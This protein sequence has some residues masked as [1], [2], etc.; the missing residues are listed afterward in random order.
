LELI[1]PDR[2]SLLGKGGRL[3]ELGIA[4]PRGNGFGIDLVLKSTRPGISTERGPVETF[5]RSGSKTVWA[6]DSTVGEKLIS[7]STDVPAISGGR[8]TGSDWAFDDGSGTP[9][10]PTTTLP[11]IGTVPAAY[12]AWQVSTAYSIGD[13]IISTDTLKSGLPGNGYY[14]VATSGGT[15][16]ASEPTWPTTIGGT[17]ADNGVTWECKGYYTHAA[18]H[19]EMGITNKNTN[20]NANPDAL[21]TGVSVT[22]ATAITR[23]AD[24]T[25]L[26]AA[27]LSSVCSDGNVFEYINDTGAS[28]TITIGGTVGNLNA[29]SFGVFAQ[30]S[31]GTVTMQ[32]TGGATTDIT[33][34]DYSLT[35]AENVTPLAITDQLEFTVPDGVTFRWVLNQLEEHPFLTSPIITTGAAASHSADSLTHPNVVHNP[36]GMAWTMG[37]ASGE[38]SSSIY[39]IYNDY[40]PLYARFTT[41]QIFM[42]DGTNV[43]TAPTTSITLTDLFRA[44]GRWGASGMQAAANGS[45]GVAKSYDG[46]FGTGI[47]RVG[48]QMCGHIYAYA[49]LNRDMGQAAAEAMTRESD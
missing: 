39:F 40:A 36:Q 25:D 22:G 28:Q 24:S 38:S 33:T 47:L 44:A 41:N 11:N 19:A 4:L 31:G 3:G 10:H 17:V 1:S 32:L 48:F 42:V 35:K 9:L 27:G 15:T 8:W 16:G 46:A 34:T 49:L 6:W 5:T 12:S 37:V 29:H 45:S 43:V 18:Y 2:A 21:L 26:A 23:Q 13:L 30:V 20:Y 7:V 14:Y